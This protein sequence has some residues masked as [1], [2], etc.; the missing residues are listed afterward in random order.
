[1]RIAHIT[2][3][4]VERRPELAELGN[5]R[6]AG[7]VNLYILGRQGHFTVA[8]QSALVEAVLAQAPD[9]VL[10]TGDLTATATEA[11][12]VAAAELLAPLRERFDW[13]VI[14]GNHDVYT[15]ESVGR[16]AQHFGPVAP[17]RVERRGTWDIVLIDVC[18]PDW[19]SRGWLGADGI[20]LLGKALSEGERPAL[21]AIHYPL[22]GRRGEPHG[23]P[24]RAC[25]DAPAIEAVCVKYPRVQMVVHGHEHR[26]YRVEIPREG[27]PIVSI[28]PGA[29]GYAHLPDDKRTAHFC[30][31]TLGD[32]GLEGVERFAFDGERFV[33]EVGGAFAT[34]G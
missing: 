21:V 6:L 14:P 9:L 4:H 3:I 31:Y 15:G 13:L 30:V 27:T 7:A 19:L 1:M 34:G 18:H 5:K 22:R 11:E 23:P 29:G 26:G 20:T 24:T 32:Q 10:C 33:P 2:D 16:F 25:I 12:F 8:A 28:D 17:V